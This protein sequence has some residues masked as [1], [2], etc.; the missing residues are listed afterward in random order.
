[1]DHQEHAG[2][3]EHQVGDDGPRLHVD[4]ADR[5]DPVGR[6]GP[7]TG[8]HR[9]QGLAQLRG[10]LLPGWREL[11]G[12]GR[13][14]RFTAMLRTTPL[15]LTPAPLAENESFAWRAEPAVPGNETRSTIERLA[16]G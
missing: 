4:G 1:M 6:R 16:I 10:P 8:V 3:Q 12:H 7:R 15:T 9:A 14:P 11:S 2:A 5:R 13:G